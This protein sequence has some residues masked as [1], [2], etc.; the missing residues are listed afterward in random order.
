MGVLQ[1]LLVVVVHL[2]AG[3]RGGGGGGGGGGRD[4]ALGRPSRA[5][6][7]LGHAGTLAGREFQ[8]LGDNPLKL[9][10]KLSIF[11]VEN[12]SGNSL[13]ALTMTGFFFRESVT[14][15]RLD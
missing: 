9:K 10:G 12:V 13:C 1:H 7:L 6:Q 3:A 4:A 11:L 14:M 5:A 2:R 15:D 8:H